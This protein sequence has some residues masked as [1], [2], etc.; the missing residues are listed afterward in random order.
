MKGWN[1]PGGAAEA[2]G[3]A[4]P[5]I[6]LESMTGTSQALFIDRFDTW[7][8]IE[9]AIKIGETEPQKT[10]VAQLSAQDGELLTGSREMIATYQKEM[11]YLPVPPLGAKARYYQIRAM[12]IRPG[13]QTDFEE[14]TKLA[15][16]ARTLD[17]APN[18][19]SVAEAYGSTRERSNKLAQDTSVSNESTLFSINPKMSNPSK[20]YIEADAAFWKPKP[21]AA[22]PA[23]KTP[24]Q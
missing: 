15:N 13:H 5:Y 20:E 8:D 2:K 23:A 9:K 7:E 24:G 3:G 1:R 4:H 16:A 21:A 19:M 11:S 14:F 6:A 18:A 10:T 12:I 17:P 22:R